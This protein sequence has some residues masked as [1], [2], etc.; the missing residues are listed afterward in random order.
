MSWRDRAVAVEAPAR[1]EQ[2]APPGQR[3]PRWLAKSKA[4]Q[5]AARLQAE[6]E[7]EA[8]RPMKDKVAAG[9]LGAADMLGYG[10]AD[11]ARGVLEKVKHPLDP[12]AYTRGRDAQREATQMAIEESP[13]AYG[14]GQLGATGASVLIPAP[15]IAGAANA[16]PTLRLQAVEGA[17]AGAKAGAL[18]GGAYGFGE[19]EGAAD[20]VLR[21]LAGTAAG[22][23]LGGAIGGGAPVVS[24]GLRLAGGKAA[25][26][27]RTGLLRLTDLSDR[28]VT[29]AD[30]HPAWRGALAMATGGKS[31]AAL[32]AARALRRFG[33]RG[34]EPVPATSAPIPDLT[35]EDIAPMFLRLRGAPV[36][37]PPAAAPAAASVADDVA[38]R[39]TPDQLTRIRN[40]LRVGNKPEDVAKA[41]GVA[42]D[43]VAAVARAQR[44]DPRR[45]GT[46]MASDRPPDYA[47]EAEAFDPGGEA[48]KAFVESRTPPSAAKAVAEGQAEAA[49]ITS[50][51]NASLA[52]LRLKGREAPGP[53]A[54]APPRGLTAEDLSTDMGAY[55]SAQ[56]AREAR[57]A[58]AYEIDPEAA[59][60]ADRIEAR[61]LFRREV[62]T[63]RHSGEPP[64]PMFDEFGNEIWQ[65]EN[66]RRA[67]RQASE[68]QAAGRPTSKR[69]LQ[70]MAAQMDAPAAAASPAA[71]PSI[72]A[73]AP[74]AQAPTQE[75]LIKAALR[76]APAPNPGAPMSS[77]QLR[78]VVRAAVKAGEP[79]K[80]LAKRLGVRQSDIQTM[81]RAAQIGN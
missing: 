22:G 8:T 28:A 60:R 4:A 41:M 12:D 76:L 73:R 21:L 69:A 35:P 81:Y 56:A 26:A 33:P 77:E 70:Q 50:D 45:G 44:T 39:L 37:P 15:K 58:R 5:E 14:A 20:S 65:Q 51:T 3:D 24:G 6:Q 62:A 75:E 49:R 7:H 32:A 63:G 19:G 42:V 68:A 79:I 34:A 31:E 10:L 2:L 48:W 30:A 23:A 57:R 36:P 59:A 47:A 25:S 16:A 1:S 55:R 27:A 11:E 53:D 18:G 38:A 9:L 40:N 61:D 43:D 29:S 54:P 66:A 46:G 67:W 71:D 17:K 80:A 74:A 78:A 72:F 52:R 13:V 64:G